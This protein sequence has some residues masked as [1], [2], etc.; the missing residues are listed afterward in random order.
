MD[1]T[2]TA[3]H[4]T[5]NGAKE[6]IAMESPYIVSVTIEGSTPI[7][8]HRWDNESIEEK[9]KARKNSKAK[10]E[11]DVGSYVYRNDAGEICIPGEY[12]RQA[13]I[14]AA[15]FKAD[16][17]SPRKSASDLFKAGVVSL[18]DIASLGVKDWDYLD[19]RRVMIQR[20]GITRTRPAMQKGWRVSFDI[21]ILIPE[22]IDSA[23]LH[24]VIVQAGRLVGIGDFRPSFGRFYVIKYEV[25]QGGITQ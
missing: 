7:L 23:L 24:E 8:F 18:T 25:Q 2:L 20:Q 13:I 15:K 9:A 14:H 3:L 6:T 12:L 17:R 5:G 10:K 16:P 22:Y 19:R 11:D 4:P 21:Q 1:K